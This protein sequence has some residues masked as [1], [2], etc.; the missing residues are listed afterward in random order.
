MYVGIDINKSLQKDFFPERSTGHLAQ[1]KF[2]LIVTSKPTDSAR[3]S[4]V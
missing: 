1:Y 4:N 3:R 2:D